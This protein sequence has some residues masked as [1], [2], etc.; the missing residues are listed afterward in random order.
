[1]TDGHDAAVLPPALTFRNRLNALLL[2]RSWRGLLP[3]TAYAATRV[4]RTFRRHHESF[5]FFHCHVVEIAGF[6]CFFPLYEQPTHFCLA[7]C[8]SDG[9]RRLL[10]LE[11]SNA[12]LF[13]FAIKESSVTSFRLAAV[14]AISFT[15]AWI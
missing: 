2:N 10:C 6:S 11:R 4:H 9:C 7:H 5:Q 1:M 3:G 8:G 15:R 13:Q 14:A 12:G